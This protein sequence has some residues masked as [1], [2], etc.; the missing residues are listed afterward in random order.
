MLFIFFNSL[1]A[2][3]EEILILKNSDTSYTCVF[4]Y[5]DNQ[6]M[7]FQQVGNAC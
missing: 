3:V 7:W 5:I 6:R 2:I 4:I 1:F